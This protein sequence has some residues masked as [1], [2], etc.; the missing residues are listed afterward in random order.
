MEKDQEIKVVA[1]NR[2][3]AH[4]YEILEKFEAGLA[5]FGS[6]IKAIR[7]GRVNFL[8]SFVRVENGEAFI[9][10]LHI[11]SY[12]PAAAFAPDPT[13]KRKLLLHKWEIRR[14]LG[15]SQEKGLTIIP[16]RLYLK[17]HLAKLEIA[18]ARGKK[19][20]DKREAIRRKEERKAIAEAMKA[21]LRKLK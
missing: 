15:K 2:R 19:E 7:E 14:L 9:H 6:E 11:G 17:N 1:V 4:Q 12:K 18:V 20:Y 21:K 8:D 16:L 5:L 13:R 3:A 10:N